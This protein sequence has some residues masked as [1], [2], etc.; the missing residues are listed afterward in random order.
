MHNEVRTDPD[1]HSRF[2]AIYAYAPECVKLIDASERL[3]DMNPAGL[4]MIDA[5]SLG[6]VRH[7]NI[8]ELIAPDYRQAF[9]E[10][11]AAVFRGKAVRLQFELV[12]FAGRRL[13][14]DQ[15]AAPLF[16]TRDSSRVVEMV[17]VTRDITVQREGEA[18]LLQARIAEAIARSRAELLVGVGHEVNAPLNDIIGYSEL[19]QEAALDQGRHGEAQDLQRIIDAARQI[20]PIMHRATGALRCLPEQGMGA[21]ARDL[22]EVVEDAIESARAVIESNGSTLAV[23]LPCAPHYWEGDWRKLDMC[24]GSLLL[25]VA[26]LAQNASV[27]AR[28]RVA[29]EAGAPSVRIEFT[30]EGPRSSHGERTSVGRGRCIRTERP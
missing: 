28:L 12:G 15:S 3:I 17:A 19:L 5:P 25:S 16:D 10:A 18:E 29:A 21:R 13:W 23:E 30:L 9:R 11:H 24:L 20:L 6:L 14:M 1:A 4:R 26:K 27:D 8:L 2:Q 7:R 22:R